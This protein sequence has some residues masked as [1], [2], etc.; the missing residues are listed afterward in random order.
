MGAAYLFT[1]T[2]C[3]A[4][5]EKTHLSEPAINCSQSGTKS[6]TKSSTKSGTKSDTKSDTKSGTKSGTK[7][8]TKSGTQS[9]TKIKSVC[10]PNGTH[11]KV[12]LKVALK[13]TLKVA[14]K[15]VCVSLIGLRRKRLHAI[16]LC[17]CWLSKRKQC[18]RPSKEMNFKNETLD[19]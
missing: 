12:A 5:H 14:L 7:S 3:F 6:D 17:I 10:V 11:L 4:V 2:P 1:R 9:G 15:K 13:V 19:N 18:D 8:D 16:S